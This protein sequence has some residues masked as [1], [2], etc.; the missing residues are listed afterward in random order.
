[1]HEQRRTLH[2]TDSVAWLSRWQDRRPNGGSE[3]APTTALSD[4]WGRLW[5]WGCQCCDLVWHV[6]GPR[7]CSAAKNEA[8]R[9]EACT[10]G[11]RPHCSDNT[12]T[13]NADISVT[14]KA[15]PEHRQ[16]GR[17]SL[18]YAG[19]DTYID[20]ELIPNLQSQSN[21]RVS[22]SNRS[23]ERWR[24]T[25]R[26]SVARCTTRGATEP[27]S[28]E[29]AVLYRAYWV[30]GHPRLATLFGPVRVADGDPLR[31]GSERIRLM[32]IEAS[33]LPVSIT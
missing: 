26:R 9:V 15:E 16:F 18:A 2:H 3:T 13:R 28:P 25:P 7:S 23:S 14:E 6:A 5:F 12:G 10:L 20:H 11:A 21:G 8:E 32:E 33:D 19:P 30:T 17:W 4:L 24:K 31:A 29:N 22:L 1:L 27:R